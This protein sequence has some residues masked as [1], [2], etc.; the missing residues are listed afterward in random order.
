MVTFDEP[1]HLPF[2][3]DLYDE[4]TTVGCPDCKHQPMRI[5]FGPKGGA[6]QNVFCVDCRQRYTVVWDYHI[7]Q[8]VPE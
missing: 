1:L 7:A 4:M 5:E 8:R 6:G 3:M 2:T